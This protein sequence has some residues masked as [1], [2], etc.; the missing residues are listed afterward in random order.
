[1]QILFA[2]VIIRSTACAYSLFVLSYRN[3]MFNQS[4][5]IFSEDCFIKQIKVE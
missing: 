4:V 1:M 5:H 2:H 3:M